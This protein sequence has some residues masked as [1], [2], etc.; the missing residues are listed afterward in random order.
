MS[1]NGEIRVTLLINEPVDTFKRLLR[2]Q[3][4]CA[5]H[6]RFPVLK[7]NNLSTYYCTKN[8]FEKNM[9]VPIIISLFFTFFQKKSNSSLDLDHEVAVVQEAVSSVNLNSYHQRQFGSQGSINDLKSFDS[10]NG[11]AAVSTLQRRPMSNN[12]NDIKSEAGSV[13]SDTSR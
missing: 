11:P 10:S 6:R 7:S 9:P 4:L 12:N 5:M 13:L 3:I 8:G 2:I 1:K